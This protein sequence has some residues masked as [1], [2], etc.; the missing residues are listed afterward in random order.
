MNIIIMN[1]EE[2]I[3]EAINRGFTY[4]AITG[5]IYGLKGKLITRYDNKGYISCSINNKHLSGHIFAWYFTYGKMPENQIDHING[6]RDDNR[7]I[8]LRDVTHQQNQW[9][10]TNAKGYTI[11]KNGSYRA[12]IKVNRISKYIG[13]FKTA[14]EAHNAYLEVKKIYH[15][16]E[17]W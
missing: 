13:T 9:N 6:I 7:I 4:D 12:Q 17:Q 15:Y 2:K 5:N 11:E 3:K 10:K 8:N 14:D 16:I 1:T